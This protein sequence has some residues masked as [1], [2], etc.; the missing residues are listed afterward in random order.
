MKAMWLSIPAIAAVLMA[1]AANAD[2]D[3]AKK[4]GCFACHAIE[5]KV[6]G[7]GWKDVAA[8][9]KGDANAKETLTNSI[10]NGSKGTWGSMA[11]PPQKR[12]SDDDIAKLVDFIMSL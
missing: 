2:A 9:Y 1:G 8:K 12:A 4:K 7:P 5:K 3:L 11:M 10:K 6:V